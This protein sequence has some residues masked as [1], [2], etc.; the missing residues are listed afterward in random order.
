MK[1]PKC[2]YLGFETGDRCKNCGYDFS[3]MGAS[4]TGPVDLPLRDP[5]QPLPAPADWAD[6]IDRGLEAAVTPP[7]VTPPAASVPPLE[8]APRPATR[9]AAP[10]LPLF[11]PAADDDEPL[12]KVPAAPR[13]PLA[14]RRTPD[15]P[16]L[17]AVPRPAA[18]SDAGSAARAAAE[19]V[20]RFAAEPEVERPAARSRR[21]ALEI[22]GPGRRLGAAAVDHAILAGIDLAVV[23]FTLKM[24]GLDVGEWRALPV[25][26]LLT[27]LALMKTTYFWAFTRIG[28]Q[29]IGKMAFGIRVVGEDDA[30]L[31]A[32]RALQRTLAGA[33]TILTLG[34]PFLPVLLAD[35][36]RAIHDRMTRTRVVALR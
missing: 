8:A 26:P 17:R 31:D 29:T 9:A 1:C 34:L 6:R 5:D 35:D 12:I 13:P 3:L 15:R 21:P 16:R 28:G 20:L 2:S 19:P 10:T 18:R 11:N 4:S 22:S 36:R 7:A 24:A 14:V 30:E 33:L 32:S 25:G 27:F 23:Y